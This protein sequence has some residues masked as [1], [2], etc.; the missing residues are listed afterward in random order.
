[1]KN[2]N[3]FSFDKFLESRDKSLYKEVRI[4]S[5]IKTHMDEEKIQTYE[6][7]EH[8]KNYIIKLIGSD[9]EKLNIHSHPSLK[10]LAFSGYGD[11][12]SQKNLLK[13]IDLIKST[14]EMFLSDWNSLSDASKKESLDHIMRIYSMLASDKSFPVTS[15]EYDYNKSMNITNAGL[16]RKP[17]YREKLTK[18]IIDPLTDIEKVLD[19]WLA[20]NK[21]ESPA[22][23]AAP[24]VMPNKQA[25][26]AVMPNKQDA[27]TE[28]PNKKDAPAVMPKQGWLSKMFS[29]K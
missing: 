20:K 24:A 2:F 15:P 27:S 28:M 11:A 23:Q 26:P 17:D 6:T 3:K 8:A 16:L 1:M 7:I 12:E 14:H 22:Q 19:E 9:D 18:H 13:T 25:A 21:P 4:T 5:A 10:F 29:S